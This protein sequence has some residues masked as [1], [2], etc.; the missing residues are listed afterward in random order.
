MSEAACL[1]RPGEEH[2]RQPDSSK[3]DHVVER[4]DP[5]GAL[6]AVR[7]SG[8]EVL[9]DERRRCVGQPP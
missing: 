6:R 5:D 9:P 7:V 4:R 3:E 1:E 2:E 8:A